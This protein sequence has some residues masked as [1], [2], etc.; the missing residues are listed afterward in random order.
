MRNRRGSTYAVHARKE[1]E[2]DPN[3]NYYDNL[4]KESRP[5]RSKTIELSYNDYKEV[6]YLKDLLQF[7]KSK[8]LTTSIANYQFDETQIP[9]LQIGPNQYDQYDPPEINVGHHYI[10]EFGVYFD[11]FASPSEKQND[12]FIPK[13]SLSTALNQNRSHTQEEEEESFQDQVSTTTLEIVR[14]NAETRERSAVD[15]SIV[16]ASFL[17]D[18]ATLPF[19][20]DNMKTFKQTGNGLPNALAVTKEYVI[21]GMSKSQIMFFPN[22][23]SLNESEINELYGDNQANSSIEPFVIG[24][25]VNGNDVGSVLSIATDLNGTLGVVGYSGGTID[26]LN[27]EKKSVLKT[28]SDIHTTAVVFVRFLSN[29][30]ILSVDYDGNVNVSV[31]NKKLFGTNI[32]SSRIINRKQYGQIVDVA[33][34]PFSVM[35][36]SQSEE[37]SA[38]SVDLVAITTTE[39]T[40][41]LTIS[42]NQAN[43]IFTCKRDA[44][45]ISATNEKYDSKTKYVNNSVS[46]AFYRNDDNSFLFVRCDDSTIDSWIINVVLFIH[47]FICSFVH[48][49]ICSFIHLFIC[50]FVYS[51]IHSFIWHSVKSVEFLQVGSEFDS[52]AM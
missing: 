39:Q 52:H 40:I 51:F 5:A 43:V 4:V 46:T 14:S 50:S 10:S 48:L 36:H 7:K 21:I 42:N 29:N 18:K 45:D 44:L 27:I 31:F 12:Y 26:I 16:D 11:L 32:T 1:F 41:I 20:A 38:L 22:E 23:A 34:I 13:Y 25:S 49:F 35:T 30:S 8:R 47:L 9:L 33:L 3:L 2:D 24:S 17:T 28:I 19:L 15:S 6:S 37:S